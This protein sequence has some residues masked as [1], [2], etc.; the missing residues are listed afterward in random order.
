[1]K[2][3]TKALVAVVLGLTVSVTLAAQAPAGQ[4]QPHSGQPPVGVDTMTV[5]SKGKPP[6]DKGL[7]PGNIGG[8]IGPPALP[9]DSLRQ[10]CLSGNDASE[11]CKFERLLEPLRGIPSLDELPSAGGG[12]KG[13]EGQGSVGGDTQTVRNVPSEHRSPC[14]PLPSADPGIKRSQ[15]PVG[16]DKPGVDRG[17][18][19]GRGCTRHENGAETSRTESHRAGVDT[20]RVQ[21]TPPQ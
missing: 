19:C 8:R 4:Y 1:M 16:Q 21:F 5:P 9:P 20:L 7:L 17:R 18:S 13:G 11:I 12:S 10:L 3:P 2:L 15:G 14:E 6:P